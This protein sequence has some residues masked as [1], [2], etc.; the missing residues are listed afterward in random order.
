MK[1]Q[2][3]VVYSTDLIVKAANNMK[4]KELKSLADASLSE[5]NNNLAIVL[6]GYLGAHKAGVGGLYAEHCQEFCK[7]SLKKIDEFK[8]RRNN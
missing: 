8:N 6:Y 3:P 4:L 1:P 5:G 2:N 7:R